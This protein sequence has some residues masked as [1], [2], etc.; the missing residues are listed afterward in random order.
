MATFER[1]DFG[2]NPLAGAN[3]NDAAARGWGPGWPANNAHKMGLAKGGGVALYVR[4]E[5]VPMVEYLLD[6][7]V[8]GDYPLKGVADDWGYASRSI[9][10]T[11]T[12]SNHSWGVAVDLNSTKN[13]M[14][15]RFVTDIPPMVV[16]M[17][18]ECGWY[19]G[20]RY[21]NRPDAMHFEYVGRLRDVVRDTAKAK[22]LMHV[23]EEPAKRPPIVVPKNG[24]RSLKLGSKG[25]DV[26]F[27]QRW[28]GIED[29]GIFGPKT[30]ARVK[31]YQRQQDL[32]VTGVVDDATWKVIL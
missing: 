25:P 27:V 1:A 18:E 19:W 7:T 10:G 14:G 29:D 31:W 11:N 20:G 16:E 9:R 6:A 24:S 12:P 5:L 30:L 4:K 15:S 26:A 28:L 3:R 22:A 17:W 21:E 2:K 13:P 8:A 23:K 32:K